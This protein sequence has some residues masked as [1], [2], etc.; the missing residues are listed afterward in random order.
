MS[1]LK[2]IIEDRLGSTLNEWL[3]E[4]NSEGATCREIARRLTETTG[5]T[6]S[7]S[8]VNNWLLNKRGE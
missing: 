3:Q 1:H 5:I 7:K 6:V 4:A 8:A 2:R